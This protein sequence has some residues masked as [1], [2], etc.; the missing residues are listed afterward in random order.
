M[1]IIGGCYQFTIKYGRTS[2]DSNSGGSAPCFGQSDHL[3][4]PQK[5]TKMKNATHN[6]AFKFTSKSEK[7]CL[8]R[9][10]NVIIDLQILM[11]TNSLGTRIYRWE[12]SVY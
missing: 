1:N 4:N 6:I 9:K 3:G 10:Y 8:P 12:C 11:T 5:Q 2:W 7:L